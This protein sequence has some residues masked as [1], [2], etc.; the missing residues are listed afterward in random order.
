MQRREFLRL[1]A[2]MSA[3][4]GGCRFFPEDGL[5]QP[6]IAEPLP[7]SLATH[8][9]M[10]RIWR[11]V[12]PSQMWDMHVHLIGIGDTSSG[13]WVNPK[14]DSLWHPIQFTQKKFYWN[15]TCI[16]D[17]RPADPAFVKRL[18]QM[19]ADFPA[20]V[21]LM[22]L[23]FDYHHDER[24][25]ALPKQSAFYTPNSYARDVARAHPNAFE[26]IA[27]IH[28]YRADAIDALEQA[29]A[30]GARAVKWLP[31]AMGMDPSSPRCDR[32]YEHL[33]KL[34]L[35]LL[36]HAGHELAVQADTAQ[37]LGNPLHLRRA[38]DHGVRVIVAHC[39]SLGESV[40]LDAGKEGP[41][42][43]NFELFIRLLR[44]ERYAHLLYGEISAMAQLLRS[45]PELSQLIA[46]RA[47]HGRLLYGSDYPLPA[48]MP[49][50][51]TR[52][53]RNKGLLNDDERE[54][55]VVLRR[56][57]PLLFDFA[58]KRLLRVGGQGFEADVFHTRRV[59]ARTSR[60]A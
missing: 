20:G 43:S 24:G 38:L 8:P 47:W 42:V 58:L 31:P 36:S 23:A 14:M 39:A 3:G 11:G 12:D 4:L 48:I 41:L 55:L 18:Q 5:T 33:A 40:D 30:E 26:W 52:D 32:F 28:P 1:V 17:Q 59:F 44:E 6:C 46:A 29:A 13:T 16:G 60:S 45:G 53:L 27:S 50:F 2:G 49:L 10:K 7:E 54:F 9:L 56:H 34:D 51:S 21:R 19:L 25:T 22:V 57:N 37:A 35:P 15:A